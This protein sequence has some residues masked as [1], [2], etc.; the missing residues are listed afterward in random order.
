LIAYE[1]DEP[2]RAIFI[3]EGPLI[4]LDEDGKSQDYFDVHKYIAMCKA[5]YEAAGLGAAMIDAMMR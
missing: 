5:H 2:M 1:H 4:W 3:V